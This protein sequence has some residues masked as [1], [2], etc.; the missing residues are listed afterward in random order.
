V[1]PFHCEVNCP[2][3]QFFIHPGPRVVDFVGRGWQPRTRTGGPPV[4]AEQALRAIQNRQRA[5]AHGVRL[6]PSWYN[7]GLVRL[8]PEGTMVVNDP[9]GLHHVLAMAWAVEE[10][11]HHAYLP[12]LRAWFE[13]YGANWIEHRDEEAAVLGVLSDALTREGKRASRGLRALELERAPLVT[14]ANAMVLRHR[15]FHGIPGTGLPPLDVTEQRSLAKYDFRD[16]FGFNAEYGDGGAV[17]PGHF[18]QID[19]EWFL[20]W[21]FWGARVVRM[22]ALYTVGE[23]A[24]VLPHAVPAPPAGTPGAV[25]EALRAHCQAALTPDHESVANFASDSNVAKRDLLA[26]EYLAALG[27]DGPFTAS[28]FHTYLGFFNQID[29]ARLRR[30]WQ[31]GEAWLE[32]GRDAG[33]MPKTELVAAANRLHWAL[34]LGQ[35]LPGGALVLAAAEA[36]ADGPGEA[37]PRG[38]RARRGRGPGRRRRGAAAR[39]RG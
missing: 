26:L 39:R 5:G 24:G 30:A 25:F 18:P 36:E 9:S 10:N 31:N 32:E 33:T 21:E 27:F 14:G 8:S 12:S 23:A 4:R 7:A 1:T 16:Q 13:T 20:T 15:L 34:R 17:D 6:P 29:G 38:P 2:E 28:S 37:G 11:Q 3:R 22:D 35:V 19:R